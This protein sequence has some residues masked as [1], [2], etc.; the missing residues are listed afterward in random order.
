MSCWRFEENRFIPECS[1]PVD[2]QIVGKGMR[3]KV[4]MRAVGRAP[5]READAGSQYG[6]CSGFQFTETD[7]MG[8]KFLYL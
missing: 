7:M 5:A 6:T 8:T 3:K 2:D 4:G 1:A